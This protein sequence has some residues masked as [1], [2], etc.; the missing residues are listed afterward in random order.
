MQCPRCGY[1]NAPGTA[2]C[3]QCGLALAPGEP[4]QPYW[5]PPVPGEPGGAAPPSGP[6][7]WRP[8]GWPPGPPTPGQYGGPPGP[9]YQPSPPPVGQ[10][11]GDRPGDHGTAPLQPWNRPPGYDAGFAAPPYLGP[12]GYA[13][14]ATGYPP[15]GRSA[16]SSGNRVGPLVVMVLAALAGFGYAGWALLH[17]RGI[18]EDFADGTSTMTLGQARSSDRWD[19]ILLVV[20]IVLVVAALTWWL[21]LRVLHRTPGNGVEVG[22]LG[23]VALGILLAAIGLVR[24]A[25]VSS[26]G[27]RHDEGQKAASAALVYGVG[28]AMIGLGLLIGL[29]AVRSTSHPAAMRSYPAY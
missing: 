22:G 16:A 7:P 12:H 3:R 4:E 21:A 13:H 11:G 2:A 27:T 8:A 25:G 9:P 5:P 6:G 19:T 17:R 26:D 14:P 15:N 20:A 1:Q 23:V 24:S 18:F 29:T 10:Y 28:F